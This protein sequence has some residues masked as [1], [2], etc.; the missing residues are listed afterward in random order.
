[1]SA[2]MIVKRGES[3][4]KWQSV[5]FECSECSH[6]TFSVTQDHVPDD[7]LEIRANHAHD[8]SQHDPGRAPDIQVDFELVA[9][10][11]VCE[12]PKGDVQQTDHEV[13]TC[14]DC[15]TTWTLDLGASNTGT[16]GHLAEG[17][18]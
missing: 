8:V 4:D 16:D 6:V 12:F 13:L 10:C 15:G 11:S 18:R 17:D 7:V 3:I 5:T 14:E 9:D 1:M 2:H